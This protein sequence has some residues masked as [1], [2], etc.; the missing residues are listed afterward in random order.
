M[1]DDLDVLSTVSLFETLL[2]EEKKQLKAVLK[3][4][5][6]NVRNARH[7]S[8]RPSPVSVCFCRAR[9]LPLVRLPCVLAQ[10]GDKIVEQGTVTAD[11]YL[12]QEG[13]C[14]ASI[15]VVDQNTGHEVT[16]VLSTMERG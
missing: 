2:P 7:P 15:N 16:K 4:C 12:I 9:G 3:K 8:S 14:E 5:R 13:V 6:F 11:F 1:T 10:Q